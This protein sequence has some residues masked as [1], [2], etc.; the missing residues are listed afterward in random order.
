[1]TETRD[2][3]DL[4]TAMLWFGLAAWGVIRR[5]QR[6]IRLSKIRLVEPVDARDVDYLSSVRRSTYLRLGTKVVLLIGSLIALFHWPLF[7]V[8]RGGVILMLLFM[9]A[10]TASVDRV[11]ERLGQKATGD[12]T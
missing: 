5:I 11:R 9:N 7:E 8:W 3:F 4:M 2:W 1:M 6:L 10:E 12:E